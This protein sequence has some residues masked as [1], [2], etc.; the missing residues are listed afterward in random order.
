MVY[1]YSRE[2]YLLYGLYGWLVS[3][4]LALSTIT[5]RTEFSRTVRAIAG[6]LLVGS[7]EMVCNYAKNEFFLRHLCI[8]ACVQRIRST[9]TQELNYSR[10]VRAVANSLD[11][12]HDH[13]RD[14][15]F[16]HRL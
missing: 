8:Y 7:L 11:M 6:M 2:A 13:G 1:N 15:M 5:Y 10:I 12:I 14:A 4:L 16:W 9:I 3:W